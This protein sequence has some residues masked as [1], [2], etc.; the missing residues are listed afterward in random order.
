MPRLL[1]SALGTCG[2][3]VTKSCKGSRKQQT[4]AAAAAGSVAGSV[5]ACGGYGY[6]GVGNQT[7]FGNLYVVHEAIPAA[8]TCMYD[9]FGSASCHQQ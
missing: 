2:S 3:A 7:A 9:D 8:N 4:V 6:A 5:A 1:L